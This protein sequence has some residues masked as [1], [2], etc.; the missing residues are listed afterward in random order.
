[1]KTKENIEHRVVCTEKVLP[2]TKKTVV[3]FQIRE[4]GMLED[5]PVFLFAEDHEKTTFDR[6]SF[7]AGVGRTI[8]LPHPKDDNYVLPRL[9]VNMNNLEKWLEKQKEAVHKPVLYYKNGDFMN[10]EEFLENSL[11]DSPGMSL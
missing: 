1:M 3:S 6:L 2:V 4:V 7:D 8:D 11:I 9:V 5:E 10:M